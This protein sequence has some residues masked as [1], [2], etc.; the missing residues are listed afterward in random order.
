[1]PF[2]NPEEFAKF[3]PKPEPKEP[4]PP[5]E[6]PEDTSVFEGKK[7][8]SAQK[9][10]SRMKNPQF[11]KY[12]HIPEKVRKEHLKDWLGGRAYL[13]KSHLPRIEKRLKKKSSGA[14]T[15][16]ERNAA[17]REIRLF[18]RFGGK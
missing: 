4:D 6:E 1:M 10:R 14:R 5:E 12:S 3:K 18:N 9:A 2:L 16:R 11:F 7:Q 13:K 17:D 8:I 15:L